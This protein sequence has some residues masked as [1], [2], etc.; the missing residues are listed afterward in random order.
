MKFTVY[1]III[2]L[3][4]TEEI[5]K[6]ILDFEFCFSLTQSLNTLKGIGVGLT[7][8]HAGAF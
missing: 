1:L 6:E 5:C 3:I 7:M 4:D 8:I 2:P